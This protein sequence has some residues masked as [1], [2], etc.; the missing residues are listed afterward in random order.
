MGPPTNG[1]LIQSNNTEI[2][3]RRGG[4]TR[5]LSRHNSKNLINPENSDKNSNQS[6]SKLNKENNHEPP[7]PNS[8][9]YRNFTYTNGMTHSIANLLNGNSNSP[10]SPKAENSLPKPEE[11]KQEDTKC[12]TNYAVKW[13]EDPSFARTVESCRKF[14]A[15]F[16]K[17]RKKSGIDYQ[18]CFGNE[19]P[20]RT[21]VRGPGLKRGQVYSYQAV[22]FSKLP[23]ISDRPRVPELFDTDTEPISTIKFEP[24]ES[25]VKNFTDLTSTRRKRSVNY[26]D[27]AQG[28]LSDEFEIPDEDDDDEDFKVWSLDN[29]T[30]K[31]KR[32]AVKRLTT[33][34]GQELS[35]PVETKKQVYFEPI[36]R[37]TPFPNSKVMKPSLFKSKPKGNESR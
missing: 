34:I 21:Q 13:R 24:Q 22:K 19:K 28:L 23:V 16:N 17:T 36:N 12:S 14:N 20:I 26:N 18:N 5:R 37:Y 31:S 2:I 33:G 6:P 25:D 29:T 11:E 15:E 3:N 10:A 30:R 8:L 7:D 9:A 35:A 4:Q 1:V 27:E 32:R